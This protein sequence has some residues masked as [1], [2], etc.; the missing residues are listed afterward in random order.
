MPPYAFSLNAAR[1]RGL[2]QVS[3][4]REGLELVLELDSGEVARIRPAGPETLPE[5][6]RWDTFYLLVQTAQE[7]A[8]LDALWGD[9][10]LGDWA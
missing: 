4:R 10:Y 6:Q 1:P 7:E 8:E 5:L 2:D 3:A 9:S